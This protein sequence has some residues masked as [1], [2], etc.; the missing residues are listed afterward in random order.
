[1]KLVQNVAMIIA[2][3]SAGLRPRTALRVYT[4]LFSLR[5]PVLFLCTNAIRY[6]PTGQLPQRRKLRRS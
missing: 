3:V 2:S 4:P 5:Q 6:M 1:M